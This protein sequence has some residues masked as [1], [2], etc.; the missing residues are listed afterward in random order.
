[1]FIQTVALS[2]VQEITGDFD[3]PIQGCKKQKPVSIVYPGKMDVG[4]L[5]RI[6]QAFLGRTVFSLTP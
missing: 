3:Y 4:C 2:V 6:L 1:M 5:I